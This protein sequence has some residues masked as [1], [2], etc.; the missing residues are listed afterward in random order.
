MSIIF[1]RTPTGILWHD[2]DLHPEFILPA[3]FE[4]L[5]R[6]LD[7]W[8]HKRPIHAEL[9]QAY[10]HLGRYLARRVSEALGCK[11][12]YRPMIA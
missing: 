10:D 3:R 2:A 5:A 1:Q 7:E 9:K 6:E 12:E 11:V 8:Y 4:L